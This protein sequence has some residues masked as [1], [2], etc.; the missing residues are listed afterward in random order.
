MS[1]QDSDQPGDPFWRHIASPHFH[2]HA[3]PTQAQRGE[4]I[5]LK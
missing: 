3:T 5:G 1:R 2:P 4:S